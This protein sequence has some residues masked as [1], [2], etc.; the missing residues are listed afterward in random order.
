LPAARFLFLF[1]FDFGS[2]RQRKNPEA[3]ISAF[4]RAFPD[5]RE[6]VG[7]IIKTINAE[8]YQEEWEKL[9]RLAHGDQRITIRNGRYT[10]EEM[11]NLIKA[12]DCYVSL[13]RSE[14]F[15]RGPAEAML[16]G[17]P[18]IVTNYSGNVDFTTADNSYLVDYRLVPVGED[19]YPGGKG[20]VWAEVDIGHAAHQ[21]QRVFERPAEAKRIGQHAKRFMAKRH[22]PGIIGKNYL[23][24]LYELEP[25]LRTG[26]VSSAPSEII[27]VGRTRVAAFPNSPAP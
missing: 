13:H 6:R 3:V 22:A 25:R 17:Q 26:S 16:L 24:R 15:G 8:S 18:I 12:C 7:L 4:Q 14:G 20:Q 19:D 10:R 9:Q 11:L 1:N 21:M 5:K 23:K 27:S 2:H